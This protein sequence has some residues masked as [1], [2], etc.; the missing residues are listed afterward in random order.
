MSPRSEL[1]QRLASLRA[2]ARRGATATTFERYERLCRAARTQGFSDLA[3]SALRDLATL[4]HELDPATAKLLAKAAEAEGSAKPGSTSTAASP[5]S[6]NARGGLDAS[7]IVLGLRGDATTAP[8]I[9]S[10]DAQTLARD[11]F[12]TLLSEGADAG[13]IATA[14]SAARGRVLV[15][16]APDVALASDA[17]ALHVKAHATGAPR[18]VLGALDREG[19]HLRPLA[20]TLER[21]GLLGGQHAPEDGGALPAECAAF[22]HASVRRETFQSAGGCDATLDAFAAVELAVRLAASGVR[23]ELVPE[24]RATRPAGLD[25]DGWLE[26]ARAMGADW[27][28]LRRKL[29]AGAPPRWLRDVGIEESGAEAMYARLIGGAD[30][31]ARRVASLRE[32]L[33]E[34]EQLLARTPARADA[35]LDKVGTDLQALVLEVT[36]HELSR[37]FVHAAL[38][39]QVVELERCATQTR[40]G[41]AVLVA[42][43]NAQ[44]ATAVATALPELPS[45]AEILV[46]VAPNTAAPALPADRRVRTFELP[47][48]AQPGAMRRALL[49]ATTADFLVLLDGSC[50][51]TR[52][53][54]EALRLTLATLPAVGACGVDGEPA[55]LASAR[56]C[57]SLP[58]SLVAARREVIASHPDDAGTFLE[59]LVRRGFRLATATAAAS[60]EPAAC[61]G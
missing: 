45:W 52:S 16:V 54:W 9:A 32:S 44:L 27:L 61:S 40:R 41:A 49:A 59:R 46:A 2:E 10:L 24:I 47:V 14:A 43:G 11:R 15:F 17:L 36:R 29:G 55:K 30:A 34:I 37:G 42:A 60:L 56:T 25:L 7:V 31:H 20:W 53:E 48:A 26:R 50:V 8:A 35:L 13:A 3:A 38:G 1:E 5:S 22:D 39:G 18:L 4:T 57:A 33:R 12:E 6:T 21:I 19:L 58:D 23:C 28:R 51:P